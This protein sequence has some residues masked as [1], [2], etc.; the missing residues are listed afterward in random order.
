M[1]R[2]LFICK[3]NLFRS[4]V[5]EKLFNRYNKNKSIKA[6]SAG[7]IGWDIS[8]LKEDKNYQIEKKVC[9][10]E[11][12]R[13][14]LKSNG[15]DY[16]VL[17]KTDFVIVVADD[18]PKQIFENEKSFHGKILVWKTKDIK[19]KTKNKEAVARKTIKFIEG[20]VKNLLKTLQ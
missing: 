4:Q 18:V 15:L 19:E 2:I 12:I 5:A 9:A 10:E 13:L 14:D 17:I 8:R 20:K 7:V 16:D 1:K 11:G 6:E 3:H